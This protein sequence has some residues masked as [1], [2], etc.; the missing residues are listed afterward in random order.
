MAVSL[1]ETIMRLK[2]S[3]SLLSEMVDREKFVIKSPRFL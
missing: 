3:Q 2:E 1:I